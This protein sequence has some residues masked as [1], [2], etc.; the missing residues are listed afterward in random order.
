MCNCYRIKCL[1]LRYVKGND[2]V[3]SLALRVSSQ[4]EWVEDI[5]PSKEVKVLRGHFA[6]W[7]IY[8]T[9]DDDA[10]NTGPSAKSF[11][12]SRITERLENY[13]REEEWKVALS[14][15]GFWKKIEVEKY[16]R[17]QWQIRRAPNIL[18]PQCG[19]WV[20]NGRY[21]LRGP[22]LLSLTTLDRS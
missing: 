5:I 8:I 17:K 4:G 1:K 13:F 3:Q 11:H 14:T 6:G 20:R 7:A 22:Q 19:D 15:L 12:L 21:H 16:L 18:G 10:R 9:V 2:R